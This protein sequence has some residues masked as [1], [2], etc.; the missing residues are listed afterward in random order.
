MLFTVR[1]HKKLL[2]TRKRDKYMKKM[3]FLLL[4]ALTAVSTGYAQKAK[5]V[6]KIF[7]QSQTRYVEPEVRVFVKPMVADMAMLTTERQY[8]G[9]FIFNLPKPFPDLMQFQVEEYKKT[10]LFQA[11]KLAE[12]DVMVAALFNVYIKEDDKYKIYIDISGFPATYSNFHLINL[13][14]KDEIEMIK[15]LYGNESWIINMQRDR[16]NEKAAE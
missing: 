16:A 12:S 2:P 15:T 14:N 6:E 8:Y 1:K 13:S 10:A 11:N 4:V 5:R 7:E 3:W 9:P